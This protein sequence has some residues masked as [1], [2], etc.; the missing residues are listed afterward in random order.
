MSSLVNQLERRKQL[1]LNIIKTNEL[2][3]KEQICDKSNL[4]NIL[5]EDILE[6]LS[7]EN[8]IEMIVN[9]RSTKWMVKNPQ[10]G[11]QK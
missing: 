3:T 8:E 4:H 2:L 7:M 1:V 11:K 6:V 10:G 5:V 9:G